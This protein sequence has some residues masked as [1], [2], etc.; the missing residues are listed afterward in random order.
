[1]TT[2][3]QCDQGQEKAE[4]TRKKRNDKKRDS[5]EHHE[6]DNLSESDKEPETENGGEANPYD[7][8]VLPVETRPLPPGRQTRSKTNPGPRR[9]WGTERPKKN[10]EQSD[11]NRARRARSNERGSKGKS[12][13]SVDKTPL[14][15]LDEVMQKAL[16]MDEYIEH[17]ARIMYIYRMQSMSDPDMPDTDEPV[18]ARE[19]LAGPLKDKY[20]ETI[21]RS[22]WENLRTLVPV[23]KQELEQYVSNGGG[24]EK[25]G[26]TMKTKMK[27]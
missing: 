1:M 9:H 5:V 11:T 25:I 20:L 16:T 19:A 21:L 17:E 8:I 4:S 26:L 27:L 14:E 6:Y 18:D 23:S 24:Y 12:R 13:L 10:R 15:I 22:E 2:N 3:D 7:T